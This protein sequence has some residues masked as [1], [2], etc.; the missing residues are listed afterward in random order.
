MVALVAVAVV[1]VVVAVVAVAVVVVVVVVAVVVVVVVVV[2]EVGRR[3]L[4]ATNCNLQRS[5]ATHL[6][7]NLR[8]GERLKGC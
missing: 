1:A 2:V 3:L 8:A 4:F 5:S 6:W 7:C